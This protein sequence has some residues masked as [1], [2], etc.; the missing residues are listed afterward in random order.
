MRVF[1]MQGTEMSKRNDAIEIYAI[2]GRLMRVTC[3]IKYQIS[4]FW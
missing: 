1:C 4:R 3:D 2:K